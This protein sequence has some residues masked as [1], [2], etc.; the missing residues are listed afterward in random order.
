MTAP[1][2]DAPPY[3][4]FEELRSCL[5]RFREQLHVQVKPPIVVGNYLSKVLG[6]DNT[7]DLLVGVFLGFEI[8]VSWA[9]LSSVAFLFAAVAP[10]MF[11]FCN[12]FFIF[13]VLHILIF[14]L[15]TLMLGKFTA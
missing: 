10:N 2:L 9:F 8:R 14:V 13:L 5:Q 1:V 6:L 4:T 15:F 12:L 3:Q 11:V 7:V